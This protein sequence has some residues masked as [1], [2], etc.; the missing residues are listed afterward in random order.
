MSYSPKC[1]WKGGERSRLGTI[2]CVRPIYWPQI[3]QPFVVLP[4]LHSGLRQDQ[5]SR[6]Y[7]RVERTS[8]FK[9]F[10]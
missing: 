5:T 6:F 3:N 4:A 8:A 2:Q 10:Y 1:C 9:G 7:L